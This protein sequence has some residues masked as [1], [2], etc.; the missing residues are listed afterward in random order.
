MTRLQAERLRRGMSQ[1]TLAAQAGRL[2]ASDI[3]RFE[4]AYGV[5]YPRQ[6][7]R[8]AHVL[9]LTPKELLESVDLAPQSVVS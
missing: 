5:P 4:R 7:E 8:L 1:T 6:A 3:S 2:S 9:G